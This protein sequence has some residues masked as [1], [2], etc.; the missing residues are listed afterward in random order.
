MIQLNGTV[1]GIF[2]FENHISDL[3]NRGVKITSVRRLTRGFSAEV[4][5]M[6]V[7]EEIQHLPFIS[8]EVANQD[9]TT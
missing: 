7:F 8:V 1:K 5:N 3:V 4:P 9:I 6:A 2:A